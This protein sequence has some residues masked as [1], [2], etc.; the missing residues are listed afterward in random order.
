MDDKMG[1]EILFLWQ[2]FQHFVSAILRLIRI[3][4]CDFLHFPEGRVQV[5]TFGTTPGPAAAARAAQETARAQSGGSEG[6]S[7]ATGRPGGEADVAEELRCLS[8]ALD[9]WNSY[10]NIK[11]KSEVGIFFA[12][13]YK[14]KDE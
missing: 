1:E 10:K 12:C 14:M 13:L 5:A 7:R 3:I 8:D 9:F 2:Q 6:A 11:M 4:L